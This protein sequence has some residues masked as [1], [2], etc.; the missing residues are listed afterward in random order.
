MTGTK[1]PTKINTVMNICN[2]NIRIKR[3]NKSKKKI[4]ICS[5]I[6]NNQSTY[7][8]GVKNLNHVYTF[9]NIILCIYEVFENFDTA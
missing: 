7:D 1:L 6:Y 5:S 9:Y 3:N 4:Y 8:S 2:I